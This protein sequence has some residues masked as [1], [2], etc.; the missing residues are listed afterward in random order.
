MRC[1][2]NEC[3]DCPPEL[4]CLKD[5]C[6]YKNVKRFYCDK[7]GYE[8]TLYE[9]DGEELCIECIT[10]RLPIVEGSQKGFI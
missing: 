4:G 6:P 10:K 8:E 5:A 1:I 3:V 7:C 2:E 9:Y